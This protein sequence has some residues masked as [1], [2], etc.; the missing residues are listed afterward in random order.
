[1][2]ESFSTSL[3]RNYFLR[4][5]RQPVRVIQGDGLES[6]P[7]LEGPYDLVFL[8]AQ[9]DQYLSCVLVLLEKRFIE[10]TIVPTLVSVAARAI[11]GFLSERGN[12]RGSGG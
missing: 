11:G 1:M 8:D 7:F 2:G 4:Q 6:I 9:R 12:H 5:G 3:A 10:R